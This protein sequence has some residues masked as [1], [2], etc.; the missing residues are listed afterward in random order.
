MTGTHAPAQ[1]PLVP[2]PLKTELFS[3]WLL[4]VAAENH[5][6]LYELIDGFTSIYPGIPLPRSLDRAID[7]AFLLGFAKFSRVHFQ[8]LN[9]LDLN[10]RLQRSYRAVLLQF[11]SNSKPSPRWFDLRAGYAFCPLCIAQDSIIHIRWDWCFA[12]LIRCSA[13]DTL[14]QLGCQACGEPDPLI[15]SGA[16]A[17]PSR[18]CRS[19]GIDLKMRTGRSK[20]ALSKEMTTI[21]QAYRAAL[22]S[23][24]PNSALLGQVTD[25]E[26]QSL[27]DDLLDL[28][29]REISRQRA[30]R[31]KWP[32]TCSLSDQ[33]R[34]DAIVDLISNASPA[35]DPQTRSNRHR[36]SLKL[37]T[38]ILCTL[39]D[40]DE[41]V[42][43]QAT[44]S[45]PTAVRARFDHARVHHERN[46]RWWRTDPLSH[47]SP[48]F[49]CSIPQQIR[50]LTA[51]NP[52]DK[53][54][55]GI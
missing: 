21:D 46:S 33:P 17:L 8:T 11:P 13:H 48:G 6:S 9:T 15:F 47:G 38:H 5:V 2:K 4:R 7:R 35:N 28:L 24:K 42:L 30:R 40:K 51:V 23:L 49:N 22:M 10:T 50:D 36:R 3:S 55:S 34:L 41:A 52:F 1:L 45:W 16:L 37:W 26:F 39:P 27:V 54:K 43:R 19:C 32:Q 31:S 14:L 20:E 29:A 53:L 18:A 44:H 12:G 25:Q